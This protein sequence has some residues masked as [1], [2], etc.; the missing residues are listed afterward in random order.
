MPTDKLQRAKDLLAKV[1]S[2]R[3][4]KPVLEGF[5]RSLQE[6]NKQLKSHLEAFVAQ[7]LQPLMRRLADVETG[8]KEKHEKHRAELMRELATLKDALSAALED[9]RAEIPELP[10]FEGMV[11]GVEQKIPDRYNDT[12]VRGL[13][14]EI[15]SKHDELG[16]T[17]ERFPRVQTPAKAYRIFT[18]DVSSQCDGNNKTFNIGSTHFGIEGVYGTDFPQIYRPVIDYTEGRTSIT[19]ASAVPAPSSGATLL[20]KFLK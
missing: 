16:K 7:K 6:T 11:R 19:L 20:V 15:Q 13:I 4:F 9:V 1:E 17:M 10:D 14:A 2:A 3:A 5:V 18:Q 12:E 8:T